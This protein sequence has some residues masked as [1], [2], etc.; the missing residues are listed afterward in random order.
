MRIFTDDGDAVPVTV[1]DVSNNRVTQVKTVDTDGYT[2]VQVAFGSRKASRVTKPEAGHLAKA[3]VEAG[4]ILKEFRVTPEV[5]AEYKPGTV[6]PVGLF[7]VGQAVD[8]QGTSIGKGFAGTIKRHNFGSQRASHG[9]S[10]SHNVPGSIGMAQDPGR[11]FPGKRMS[12]HMGDETVTVQN[13]DIVRV[14]AERSLLLVKGAIPG[15]K[16]GHVV[17]RHAVKVK[18]KKGAN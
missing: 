13:L 15:S 18:A 1:I 11:V 9:N 16:N 12:G 5:A 4:T 3:G 6:V 7:E 2:G 10:R 8:V 14:D 17:V